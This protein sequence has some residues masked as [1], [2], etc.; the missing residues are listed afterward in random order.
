M[1]VTK[2]SCFL[3]FYLFILTNACNIWKASDCPKPPSADDEEIVNPICFRNSSH[4][5]WLVCFLV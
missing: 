2:H 4:Q 3:W 5:S 1:F